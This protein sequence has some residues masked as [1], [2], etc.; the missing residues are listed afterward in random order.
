MCCVNVQKVFGSVMTMTLITL[1]T[2]SKYVGVIP[3]SVGRRLYHEILAPGKQS[4]QKFKHPI[5]IHC[6]F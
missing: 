3:L 6:P 4:L 5:S 1:S 2:I